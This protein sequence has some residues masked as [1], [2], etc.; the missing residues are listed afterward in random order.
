M[1][2]TT[3]TTPAEVAEAKSG[4]IVTKTGNLCAEPEL[5]YGASGTAFTR[6]R[7]AVT[8]YRQKGEPEAETQFYAVVAF[9]TLAENAA[10]SLQKGDRVIVSGRGEIERW[11]GDDGIE[12]TGKKILA[13]S[14]GPDLRFATATISRVRHDAPAQPTTL[15]DEGP[16]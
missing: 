2:D 14:L 11:T 1:T 6:L 8:P 4:P 5:R 15:D 3:T 9:G 12:R 16:F 13:D 7:I 10:E